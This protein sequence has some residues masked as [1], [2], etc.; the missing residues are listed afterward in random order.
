MTVDE[1]QSG[2][3]ATV[4]IM[5]VEDHTTVRQALALVL[6]Q[7]REFEVV[8]QAGSLAEARQAATEFDVAIVDLGL[9][10][11]HGADVITELRKISPKSL[12][13]VLTAS[14]ERTELARAVEAGASGLLH[15]ATPLEEITQ[16]VRR[17]LAGE[18]LISMEEVIELLRLATSERKKDYEEQMAAQQLTPREREI[19]QALAEGLSDRQIADRLHIS[20]E[21]ERNHISNIFG[22]LGVDSR[23][24]AL[25]FAVRRGIVEIR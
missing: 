13:L 7:E 12:M 17:L 4:R 5:L 24:Q 25:L 16:A 20:F 6:E 2:E 15:K 8:A 19:L 11:G 3:E 23:L 1:R 14:F 9:P 18:A 22:K 21:T 10:D